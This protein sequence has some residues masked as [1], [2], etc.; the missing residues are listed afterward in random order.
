MLIECINHLEL[1]ELSPS[2]SHVVI[3]KP[4]IHDT[5]GFFIH[6]QAYTVKK[7]KKCAQNNQNWSRQVVQ[8]RTHLKL[9]Q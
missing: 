4:E 7:G 5:D 8:E 2:K 9:Q 6:L 1:T 3:N